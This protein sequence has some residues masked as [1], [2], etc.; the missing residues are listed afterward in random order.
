MEFSSL[1]SLFPCLHQASLLHRG[2]V[3]S[4]GGQPDRQDAPH[5]KVPLNTSM[6]PLP[7]L[8][9][10]SIHLAITVLLA[11]SLCAGGPYKVLHQQTRWNQT[12]E[13]SHAMA[14]IGL[15]AHRIARVSPIWAIIKL[16]SLVSSCFNV[17]QCRLTVAVWVYAYVRGLES[18]WN[19]LLLQEDDALLLMLLFWHPANLSLPLPGCVIM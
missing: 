1:S 16:L 15:C 14:K 7:W 19:L 5:V 3:C 18:W 6:V 17:M 4:L 10:C 12:P 13:N 11:E 9:M 8:R 2:H